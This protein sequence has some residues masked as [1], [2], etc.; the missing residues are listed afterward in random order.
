MQDTRMSVCCALGKG[1]GL[2]RAAVLDFM[3]YTGPAGKPQVTSDF[4][5]TR[6]WQRLVRANRVTLSFPVV[7]QGAPDTGSI[8]GRAYVCETAW[9]VAGTASSCPS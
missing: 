2:R 3:P 1:A 4:N 9:V 7:W 6:I 8:H 5:T